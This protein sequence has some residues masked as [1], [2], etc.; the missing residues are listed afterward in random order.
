MRFYELTYLIKPDLS[1]QGLR[2]L[3]EK[4]NSFIQEEG[5][6]LDK[7][8]KEVRKK[9]GYPI[10]KQGTAFLRTTTF[11]LGPEKLGSLEKKI[12]ETSEILR[13]IF[14]TKKT[15]KAVS[16]IKTKPRAP[17]KIKPKIKVELKEIEKKLEEILE[18]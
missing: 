18:E 11:Y 8:L 2:D 10:Q 6:I 5:G 15:P 17:K 9:L 3:S 4:V 7:G 12:K 14:L 1:E 16:E 13:Y